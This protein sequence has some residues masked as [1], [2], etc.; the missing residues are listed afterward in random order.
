M[1]KWIVGALALAGLAW[2]LVGRGNTAN[3]PAASVVALTPVTATPFTRESRAVGSVEARVLNLSFAR[4]GRVA[5]VLVG[6]GQPVQRNQLL[7]TLDDSDERER[8]Q[9]ARAGLADLEARVLSTRAQAARDAPRLSNLEATL[10]GRVKLS[11]QLEEIG[12]GSLAEVLEA[13]RLLLETRTGRETARLTAAN[14]Q[15]DLQA[16]IRARRTEIEALQRQRLA[17]ELRAPVAGTVA[18]LAVV[19]GLETGRVESAR[20]EGGGAAVRLVEAGSFSVRVRLPEAQA[21]FVRAGQPGVATLDAL[22]GRTL[23]VK[24]DRLAVQA[25]AQLSGGSATVA[26]VLRFVGVDPKVL[27]PGVSAT[28]RITTLRIAQ[29]LTVPLEALLR[30]EGNTAS[31][32]VAVGE[33]AK[34]T[35]RQRSVQVRARNLEVAVVGGLRAG[36][37][38]VVLP[39]PTLV[40]GGVVLDAS[41]PAG[42]A[43]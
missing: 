22:P 30:G 42:G 35:V 36:E 33:N 21:A 10:Q 13:E 9:A 3:A 28:V 40:E 12:A 29:A 41:A 24:V 19:P 27:R 20:T 26:V 43:R 8:I 38:V 16:Q 37:R 1:W 18:G 17:L 39:P 5:R 31:V 14:V 23:E 7:A 34:L 4:A 32:W 2:W 6:E 15:L 11:R 25:E